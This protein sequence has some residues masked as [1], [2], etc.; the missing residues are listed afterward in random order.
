MQDLSGWSQTNQH[1]YKI[2]KFIQTCKLFGMISKNFISVVLL[3][4]TSFGRL[5]L[6]G[7]ILPTPG[8]RI[9]GLITTPRFIEISYAK[10]PIEI[11]THADF[12]DLAKEAS[13][14]VVELRGKITASSYIEH[15]KRWQPDLILA[16]GWYYMVPKKVREST[17]LGTAGIHASALP[18]YRGGAPIPWA[19]IH[20]EK[21]TG[22]SFFYFDD[23]V[24]T[25]DI[26]AQARFPIQLDDTCATVYEKATVAS[27]D[28]LREYL[29][30]MAEG[31]APCIRQ[32]EGVATYFPQRKPEDGQI[33][34]SWNAKNIYD[35]IRAQTRPYPGAFTFWG[36]KKITVWSAK[37][38]EPVSRSSRPGEILAV[39]DR[40][41]SSGMIVGTGSHRRPIMVKEVQEEGQSEESA[42]DF[43]L[44]KGIRTETITRFES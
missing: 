30:Q 7:G 1:R 9:V 20:G 26:I 23:G 37:L 25:G 31:T 39:M 2:V 21:E 5:C 34:W 4:S 41:K 15:L 14:E 35:F 32:D 22:V 8:V 10:R 19:I 28:I 17:R 11:S 12:R 18:K 27:V 44:R 42:I 29:P 6:K 24:D 33:D 36:G 13:C 16:L 43:A 40:Q 38:L 3:S